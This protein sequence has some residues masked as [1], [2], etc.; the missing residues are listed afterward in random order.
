MATTTLGIPPGNFVYERRASTLAVPVPGV[1]SGY[2]LL[3]WT[4]PSNRDHFLLYGIGTDQHLNSYYEWSVDNVVLPI[5]G[6]ARVGAPEDPYVFPEPIYVSGTIVLKV[7][8]G[9]GVGYPRIDPSDPDAEY[10]YECVIVGRY[11]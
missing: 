9:N 4:K 3:H 11:S 1:T 6:E 7:S 10:S 2:M 5:S 8:N